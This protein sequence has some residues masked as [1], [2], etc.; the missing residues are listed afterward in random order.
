M[1]WGLGVF[2]AFLVLGA[3]LAAFSCRRTWRWHGR[4]AAV[5]EAAVMT[6]SLAAYTG[7]CL[8]IGYSIAAQC[9]ALVASLVP[10]LIGRRYLPPSIRDYLG[11]TR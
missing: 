7:I 8:W 9:L 4:A 1:T 5:K 3:V 11:G 2:I 6:L 10:L